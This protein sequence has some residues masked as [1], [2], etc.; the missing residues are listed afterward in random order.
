M[1]IGHRP[2]RHIVKTFI[3]LPRTF[4]HM[5]TMSTGCI[6]CHRCVP[7]RAGI[8]PEIP[9]GG[10]TPG[11]HGIAMTLPTGCLCISTHSPAVVCTTL[12]VGAQLLATRVL[13]RPQLQGVG[14]SPLCFACSGELTVPFPR[15]CRLY[16]GLYYMYHHPYSK[17]Y[18]VVGVTDPTGATR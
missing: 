13:D 15:A 10:Q 5:W 14:Q 17:S 2:I 6:R 16:L 1:S 18:Q 7:I 3:V 11:S 9:I 4:A 8:F 12:C